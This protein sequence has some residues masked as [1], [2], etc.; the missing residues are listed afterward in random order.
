MTDSN[1]T[2]AAELYQLR[3]SRQAHPAGRFDNAGRWYPDAT[4]VRDCCASVRDPSRRFPYAL[5]THCRTVRHIA[6]LC[7]VSEAALREA[8]RNT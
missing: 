4:E 1:I 5:L 7:G 3:Q 2:H 8:I 6:A